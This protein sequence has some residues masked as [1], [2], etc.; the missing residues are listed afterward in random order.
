M[1]TCVILMGSPGSGKS[2]YADLLVSTPLG[3]VR[4]SQDDQGK[5]G[6]LEAFKQALNC[7]LNI[8]VDRMNFN[9]KQRARY[10]TL[11]KEAGYLIKIVEFKV[12]T[13][14]CLSRC[15]NRKDHPNIKDNLTAAKVLKFYHKNYE[16]PTIDEYDELDI[17]NLG[18]L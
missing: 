12:S 7:K 15:E 18:N 17:V 13:L 3:Y 10:I 11:A 14:L 9:K 2:A 8:V 4:I 5:E 1:N 16:A 6:H